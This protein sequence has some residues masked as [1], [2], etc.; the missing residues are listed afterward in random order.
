[1]RQLGGDRQ[2]IWS[3]VVSDLDFDLQITKGY[4][5]TLEVLFSM[6][7][8]LQTQQQKRRAQTMLK[9]HSSPVV[10]WISAVLFLGSSGPLPGGC[11]FE[12]R[13]SVSVTVADAHVESASVHART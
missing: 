5:Y 7:L 13:G 12:K 6:I 4:C 10:L 9:A 1:M 11:W 8:L 2:W 3:K